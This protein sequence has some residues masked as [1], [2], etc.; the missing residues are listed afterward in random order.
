MAQ[1]PKDPPLFYRAH[2]FVCC[3]RRPDGHPRGSCAAKGSEA[4]RRYMKARVKE[5]GL[6]GIRVNQAGCLD[7]CELGPCVVVYPE[8]VWYC[9][10]T[11][12]E[13]EQ[14]IQVHLI[15]AGRPVD[16]MLDLDRGC[17]A[18]ERRGERP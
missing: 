10:S 8:G 6:A 7:R 2:I 17:E 4:V 11:T 3:N 9:V 12:E 1:D 15:G 18:S 16:L 14:V 13:A 5:L